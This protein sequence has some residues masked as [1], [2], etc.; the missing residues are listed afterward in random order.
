M[1]KRLNESETFAYAYDTAI[2][3]ADNNITTAKERMQKQLDI[4]TRWSHDNGLIINA[5]K[6]KLIHIKPPNISGSSIEIKFHNTDCLHR[7]Q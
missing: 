4:A 5:N 2:V 7:N 3:I 1:L 6:T